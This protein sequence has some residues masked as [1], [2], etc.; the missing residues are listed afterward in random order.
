MTTRL[1]EAPQADATVG[2]TTPATGLVEA[3]STVR[4][5][6]EQVTFPAVL[7]GKSSVASGIAAD[8]VALAAQLDDFLDSRLRDDAVPTALPL[9]TVVTGPTGVGKSTIINTL[10]GAQVSPTG[11]LRPTTRLPVLICHPSDSE[12]MASLRLP[13]SCRVM[14]AAHMPDNTVFIDVPDVDSVLRATHVEQARLINGSPLD[15]EG[16]QQLLASADQWLFVTTAA[17]YADAVPWRALKVALSRGTE[18]AV[19]LNRVPSQAAEAVRDHMAQLLAEH[20]LADVPLF[21][22]G[23]TRV[24][25]GQLADESLSDVREWLS[26]TSVAN[27]NARESLTIPANVEPMLRTVWPRLSTIAGHVERQLAAAKELSASARSAYALAITRIHGDVE[28][29]AVLRGEALARWREFVAAGDL[30]RAFETRVGRWSALMDSWLMTGP[31]QRSNAVSRAIGASLSALITAALTQACDDAAQSWRT[32]TGGDQTIALSRL[33][34]TR[35]S[36]ELPGAVADLVTTWQTYVRDVVLAE[37]TGSRTS[38]KPSAYNLSATSAVVMVAALAPP[39]RDGDDP[40]AAVGD[41]AA[42]A[43]VTDHVVRRLADKVRAELS[44]RL[45][46]L[47]QNSQERFTSAL[48][49]IADISAQAELPSALRSAGTRVETSRKELE[50]AT[51]LMAGSTS[52]SEPQSKPVAAKKATTAQKPANPKAPGAETKKQQETPATAAAPAKNA[53]KPKKSAKGD[54]TENTVEQPTPQAPPISQGSSGATN[55]N[56]GV[57]TPEGKD[58]AEGKR[59]SEAQDL[60][61]PKRAPKAKDLSESKDSREVKDAG[62]DRVVES[63]G[64]AAVTEADS[65][66]VKTKPKKRGSKTTVKKATEKETV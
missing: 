25:D 31:T 13:S 62:E 43:I 39:P 14:T 56:N 8:S 23:E 66:K 20:D 65:A 32:R 42:A 16:G 54:I 38:S 35:P 60:G 1:G 44:N 57:G 34:L 36:P 29:G 49:G 37:R 4:W 11:V 64:S 18:L 28:S 7:N 3:L 10:V 40:D 33:D 15:A 27:I 47:V 63:E 12:R 45:N 26:T 52:T 6:L 41:A 9:R 51:R 21:V 53:A 22:I 24:A 58:V 61:E 46:A 48:A 55:S 50:T 59:V 5:L 19:A 2:P 30:L 17:R